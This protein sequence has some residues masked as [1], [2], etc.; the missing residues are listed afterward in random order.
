MRLVLLALSVI[1]SLGFSFFALDPSWAARFVTY[2][3]YPLLFATF[4]IFV[5]SL[6]KIRGQWR[7]LPGQMLKSPLPVLTIGGCT[8]FL[9]LQEPFGFKILMD[10]VILLGT[11][12]SMHFEK[13]VL[14]PGMA[15]DYEG[16]FRIIE[17]YLDK[18][19][20]FHPFLISLLHDL[21]GYRP[22]NAFILNIILTPVML[23]LAYS[24][25]RKLTDQRGGILSVLLLTSLPLLA[26]NATGGHFEIL[27]LVMI[28]IVMLLACRYLQKLDG[29]S[30]TAFCYAG[31]L[32]AQTRYEAGVF[33]IPIGILVLL[34]WRRKG[35]VLL[36]W[37][38]IF[39]PL[40]LVCIPMQFLISMSKTYF[41]Q[42]DD[43]DKDQ[44]FSLGFIGENLQ[45]AARYFFHYGQTN[46]N[47]LLLSLLGLTAA[48]C[49][50]AYALPRLGRFTQD[51]HSHLVLASFLLAVLASFALAMGY[52]WGQLT[53]PVA[54]RFCLPLLLMGALAAPLT[55]KKW[56]GPFL[57]ITC[58]MFGYTAWFHLWDLER[59]AFIRSGIGIILSFLL[60]SAG[61]LYILRKKRDPFNFVISLCLLFILFVTVPVASNHRYTGRYTPAKEASIIRR[62]FQQNPEK[63]YFFTSRSPLMAI[64]HGVSSVNVSRVAEKPE[65]IWRHYLHHNYS[66]FYAF[67]L[68]DVNG[69]TGELVVVDHYDLGPAFEIETVVEERLIPL[70]LARIVRFYPKEDYFQNDNESVEESAPGST[71]ETEPV[72][73]DTL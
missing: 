17:A 24:F 59:L 44:V 11:S 29:P 22:A 39:A 72:A 63:D 10:E 41:W 18:R 30:L 16:S 57:L 47:S 73:A 51:Q 58:G 28:L 67:Q 37:P 46:S 60:I 56:A 40:Q 70:Q 53:D 36:P 1:L 4:S 48:V 8:G 14:V 7:S 27:N 34:G 35:E 23:S 12:M 20:Y 69:E 19:P 66:A 3:G 5:Y 21:T 15:N 61:T 9:F 13:A 33:V 62:F 68:V 42:L 2:A 31:L 45:D 55:L 26:Q 64:T 50:L 38:V 71:E 6:F 25:G 65:T 54:S 43:T 52:H 49:F 32:L